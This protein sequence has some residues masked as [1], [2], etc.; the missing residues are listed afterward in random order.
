MTAE[1]VTDSADAAEYFPLPKQPNFTET[2]TDVIH[3]I[4]PTNHLI[5]PTAML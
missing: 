4:L 3:Y 1:F 2:F 5:I